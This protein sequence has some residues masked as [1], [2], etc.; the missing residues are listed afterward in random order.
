MMPMPRAT[1][2]LLAIWLGLGVTGV[3]PST[4]AR[5]TDQ[6]R[7]LDEQ[8]NRTD[9]PARY[10][11]LTLAE[12]LAL[13]TVPEGYTVPDWETV[14]TQTRRGVSLEG[15]IA[16]V[17]RASDGATYGRPPDQGDIHL[18]LRPTGEPQADRNVRQPHSRDQFRSLRFLGLVHAGLPPDS[19]RSSGSLMGVVAL[20]P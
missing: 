6:H 12:F 15:Y 5:H 1:M 18:H 3:P 13:P 17:I 10:E 7:Y 20:D 9:T 11:R 14:R 19:D 8:K 4:L 16:E 2:T